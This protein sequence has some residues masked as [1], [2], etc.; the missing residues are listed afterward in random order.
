MVKGKH[1]RPTIAP[2][3][4]CGQKKSLIDVWPRRKLNSKADLR[5][6]VRGS[7]KVNQVT[8]HVE[9][10]PITTVRAYLRL[11]FALARR[12]GSCRAQ[13]RALALALAFCARAPSASSLTRLTAFR[14]TCSLSLL[15]SRDEDIS[16]CAKEDWDYTNQITLLDTV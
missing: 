12:A 6:P 2:S 7:G 14:A 3:R 11:I 4:D 5:L 10:Q 1:T 16:L 8:N 9:Q 15:L 13:A